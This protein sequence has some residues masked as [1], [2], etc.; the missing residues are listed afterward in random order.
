MGAKWTVLAWNH[1]GF[2]KIN[3]CC[4][5]E[6]KY[7]QHKPWGLV[8]SETG[9][10]FSTSEETAYPRD[11]AHAIAKVF[12]E[13]LVHHGWQPPQDQLQDSEVTLKSMRAVA[14]QNATSGERA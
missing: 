14:I 6:S 13:I 1:S 11:L 4:P 8:K 5:G 12:A 9:T 7:H 2:S 10:H 3:L